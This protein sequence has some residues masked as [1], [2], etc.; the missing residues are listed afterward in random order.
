MGLGVKKMNRIRSRLTEY[1]KGL[2]LDDF[3]HSR[4]DGGADCCIKQF[5]WL[6]N[7]IEDPKP[8]NLK[9]GKN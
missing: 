1:R 3:G 5:D 7:K 9:K 2:T 6:R 8:G 4:G